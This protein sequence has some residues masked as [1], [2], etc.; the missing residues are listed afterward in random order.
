MTNVIILTEGSKAI[1][2]GHISRCSALAQAFSK[3]KPGINV[4]FIV[5]TD[6]QAKV[7]LASNNVNFVSL[8]WLKRVDRIQELVRDETIIIVDSYQ[9]PQNF[10]KRLY[11]FEYKPFVVAMDDYNRIRY[12]ADAIINVSVANK[13]DASYK[14]RKGVKYLTGNKYT[15]LRREFCGIFKKNINKEVKDVLIVFGGAEWYKLITNIINLLNSRGFNLH[16]V[17]PDKSVCDFAKN[18]GYYSYSNLN[19]KEMCSLMLKIDLCIAGGGQTINELAYLGV[20][21]IAICLARNQ[22]ENIK[23]WENTGF[24]EYIGWYHD[25]KLFKRLTNAVNKFVPYKERIRRNKVGR[26]CVDGKGVLRVTAWIL[27]KSAYS[28]QKNL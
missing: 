23:H 24:L 22:L 25:E 12:D 27:E 19:A 14:K 18:I 20:P 5:R 1:G 10:Y 11:M 4:K 28:K 16:I 8:D 17:S 26:S 7:F 15:I 13:R 6:K 2:Y 3:I 21:T 9:A